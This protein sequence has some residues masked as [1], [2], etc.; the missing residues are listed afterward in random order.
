MK[1]KL[2]VASS[3]GINVDEGFGICDLF[4]I[5]EVDEVGNYTVCEKRNVTVTDTES[6]PYAPGMKCGGRILLKAEKISDCKAV[7][8]REI[9]FKVRKD[10]NSR[11][12]SV[13]DIEGEIEPILE[14]IIDYYK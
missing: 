11:G 2:A 10:L 3:D 13:F 1:Y 8:C 7:I 4:T 6:L 12:I 14:K 9:G 5:Y